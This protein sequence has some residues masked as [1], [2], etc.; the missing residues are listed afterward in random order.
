MKRL[1]RKSHFDN[2][3]AIRFIAFLA[4]FFSH[5]FITSNQQLNVSTLFMDLR[6]VTGNLNNVAYSLLFILTGFLNTWG[7][8][9][10]RFIYKK[11]NILRYYVRR[12]LTLIPLYLVIFIL[13]YYVAPQVQTGLESTQ[14]QSIPTWSYLSFLSNF[15]YTGHGNTK[16]LIIGNMW[17]IAVTFQFVIIWPLLMRYFR[18]NEV[19]LFGLC[20][21]VFAGASYFYAD[22]PGFRYNTLNIL[23]DFVLGAYLAYFSFFKYKLYNSLKSN[24]KRTNAAVYLCFF[25]Y[26]LF[27]EKI[28]GY[29]DMIPSQLYFILE[30]LALASTLAYFVFEQNFGSNSILKLAKLKIFNQP[31]KMVYGMYAYHAIGLILG[32]VIME[33]MIDKQG[34]ASV[35]L[36]EPFLALIVTTALTLISYEFFEKKFIRRKKNYQ[37]SREYNPVGLQDVKTKPA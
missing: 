34:A 9:E 2:L 22:Q 3:Y 33:F 21:A 1:I 10:E 26:I 17:S 6:Q 36:L 30:R 27:R 23:C 35:L 37:P 19:W 11:M 5:G 13:G 15:Y 18:R 4:I 32:Y 31:G 16:H 25:S 28:A 20:I 8:F 14:A 24:T 12:V 29:F 7:I